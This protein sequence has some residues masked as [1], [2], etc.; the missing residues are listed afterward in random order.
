MVIVNE[1][2]KKIL[3]AKEYSGAGKIDIYSPDEKRRVSM[4]TAQDQSCGEDMLTGYT[5]SRGFGLLSIAVCT[6]NQT[7]E[8][9]E[10]ILVHYD[11]DITD[12]EIKEEYP[13]AEWGST[14]T[15]TAKI[16]TPVS[17]SGGE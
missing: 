12:L 4:G 7:I 6:T 11:L 17:I 1:N 8:V 3:E 15:I 10:Q 13:T 14:I 2:G 9:D 5:H 16:D